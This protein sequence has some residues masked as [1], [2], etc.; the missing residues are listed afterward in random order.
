MQRISYYH[1][2]RLFEVF[3]FNVI[4]AL[5]SYHDQSKLFVFQGL[6]FTGNYTSY[7]DLAHLHAYLQALSVLDVFASL[8]YARRYKNMSAKI[9]LCLPSLACVYHA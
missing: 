5:I 8:R 3:I 7:I 4:N 9:D 1:C 6:V 2:N